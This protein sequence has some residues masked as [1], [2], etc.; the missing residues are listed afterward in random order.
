VHGRSPLEGINAYVGPP[1]AESKGRR[2]G[3]LAN[4]VSIADPSPRMPIRSAFTI[5]YPSEDPL[6]A[7]EA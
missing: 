4:E 3:R 6:K 2:M 1:K 7:A 5:G